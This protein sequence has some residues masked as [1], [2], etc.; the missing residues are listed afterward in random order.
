MQPAISLQV[1]FGLATAGA[2]TLSFARRISIIP[3]TIKIIPM[4]RPRPIYI[5]SIVATAACIIFANPITISHAGIVSFNGLTNQGGT[6]RTSVLG[7]SLI[8]ITVSPISGSASGFSQS[9]Q[10]SLGRLFRLQDNVPLAPGD[11]VS[12]TFTLAYPDMVSISSESGDSNINDLDS[13]AIIALGVSPGFAWIS[14]NLAPT[15]TKI[16]ISTT[17]VT[18]DTVTISGNGLGNLISPPF[19]RFRVTPNVG[20]SGFMIKNTAQASLGTN[21]NSCRFD[22]SISVVPEPPKIIATVG[23]TSAI[24][25][26]S[27]LVIGREYRIMRSTSL[28][29]WVEAYRFTATTPV[30]SWSE[31]LGTGGRQFYR[32][33]WNN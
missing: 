16:I 29:S 1:E 15:A 27:N 24:L 22:V 23:P 9:A 13:V 25:A 4:R 26:F 31:A 32:L 8:P 5:A 11:S 30:S 17:N 19:A 20:I 3:A 14:E 28:A 21:F 2:S 10:G 6:Y 12:T 18:N 33:E 7:E